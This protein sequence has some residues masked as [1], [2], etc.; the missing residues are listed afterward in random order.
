[1][2]GE[3][4]IRHQGGIENAENALHTDFA[5]AYIGGGVLGE[6]ISSL[7][8]VSFFSSIRSPSDFISF[9][10]VGFLGM[11]N[12]QEEIR[13]SVAPECLCSMLFNTPMSDYDSIVI[14]G[15]EQFSA[16]SGYGGSLGFAGDY[17]DKLPKDKFMRISNPVTF[18]FF[19][20]FLFLFCLDLTLP[21]VVFL[22]SF[23]FVLFFFSFFVIVVPFCLAVVYRCLVLPSIAAVHHGSGLPRD[24]QI[25]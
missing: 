12:V 20:F 18:L 7:L 16:Y 9:F 1:V 4:E 21:F 10:F 6:P 19:S 23:I 25:V 11:G 22:L 2:L 17:V 13:F 8:F 5:N 14:V 15:A 24:L 3:F